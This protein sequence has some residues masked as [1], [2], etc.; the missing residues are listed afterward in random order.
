MSALA[1]LR[2]RSAA[3]LRFRARQSLA[4]LAERARISPDAGEPSPAAFVRRGLDPA[5]T[6]ARRPARALLD[7]FRAP[8][9][10]RF[11]P[12]AEVPARTG[13]ALRARFPAAAEALVKRADRIAAGRFDLLGH[14]GLDFGDPIDWSLDPVVGIRA[15]RVHRSRIDHLDARAVGDHKRVWELN[16]HHHLVTLGRA[17]AVT[18][19]ERYAGVFA[20][21]LTG[22]MDANPPKTGINWA[23]SLEL[24]FRCVAWTWALHLFRSSPA[25]TPALFLR[26]LAFLRLQARHVERNLS[27][28]F[29]PNTHLTG[30]ALG[31]FVVGTAFPELREAPRWRRLG[32]EVLARELA[33]QVLADGVYFERASAYARYTADFGL[34]LKILA[35]ANGAPLGAAEEGALR[36]LLDHLVHL[37]RPDGTWPLLGD[38]DGGRLLSLDERAPDDFRATLATAAAVYDSAE[39]RFAA[40]EAAEETLWLLGEDGVG[41]FDAIAPTPPAEC[42]RS[43]PNGGVYVLRDGWRRDA[44]WMVVDCG[45]HGA[46]GGGHAHADALAIELAVAGRTVLVDP[47]TFTYTGPERDRFRGTAA[48]CTLTV[49]GEP[50]SLPGAPFRWR[51]AAEGTAL[52]WIVRPRF[53]FFEGEHDGY[54][55]LPVPATH[56]RAILHLAGDYWIVRDRVLSDGGHRAR[57]RLQFAAGM[58]AEACADGAAADGVHVLVAAP[59]AR[60][61]LEDGEVSRGYGHREAASGLTVAAFTRPGADALVTLLVPAGASDERPRLVELEAAAGEALHVHTPRALDLLAF[62]DAAGRLEAPGVSGDVDWLWLR[63]DPLTGQPLEVAAIGGTRLAVD[64]VGVFQADATA[65]AFHAHL[66]APVAAAGG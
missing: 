24:A 17:Y 28:W 5:L 18:G 13:A 34:H 37:G 25:L 2:G 55:R 8:G 62:A 63:R 36:R 54:R 61:S 23:S 22:W 35:A 44:D 52:R 14:R 6:P 31:L 38:D 32:R 27:T 33:R 30:E 3:E 50:A 19:D 66:T 39:Y 64:G 15:P 53:T 51:T 4:A 59:E 56:R 57:L 21:H 40:R 46:P 41:R 9:R 12:G 65:G 43:F 7:A 58:R 10:P 1:K 11:F 16:R 48:H 42:A 29:S 20:A 49:D 26:A 47:G 45:P 60:C